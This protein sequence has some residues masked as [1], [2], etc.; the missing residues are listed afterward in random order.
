M[1]SSFWSYRWWG[2]LALGLTGCG[3]RPEFYE[4]NFRSDGAVG[5]ASAVA[6][7]DGAANRVAFLRSPRALE[8]SVDYVPVGRN[9]R[10]VRAS[11]DGTKLFVLSRGVARRRHLDDERP[12][13]TVIDASE[14]TPRVVRDDELA[15]GL[16]ALVVDDAGEWAVIY[17]FGPSSDAYVT[18]PNELILVDLTSNDEPIAVSLDSRGGR[19]LALRFTGAMRMPNGGER[20]FLVVLR[21]HDIA[22][23]DLT[24]LDRQVTVGSPATEGDGDA[25]PIEV[26]EFSGSREDNAKFAIRFE[27]E[28]TIGIVELAEPETG[29]KDRA[30]SI[31]YNLID[32]GGVASS[33]EYVRTDGGVRLAAVV[34]STATAQLIDTVSSDVT[35]VKLG[36][37]FSG[38]KLVTDDID[39]RPESGDVAIL[40]SDRDTA[41]GFWSLGKTAERAY[42]SLET[43]DIGVTV[44]QV[45]DVPGEDYSAYKLLKSQR[46]AQFFVL[47]LNRRRSF[48][49]LALTSAE[50]SVSLD[51]QRVWAYDEGGTELARVTFDDL[52]PVSL[53]T[54]RSI[55]GVFDI[56]RDDGGRAAIALHLVQGEGFGATVFDAFEPDSAHS[57]FFSGFQ[58]TEV[59]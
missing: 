47:D 51:G 15:Q 41:V 44:G 24:D 13:F 25:R 22:L 35:E 8:L 29:E 30:F 58:L 52:H 56:Q 5:L 3:D 12:R 23:V 39:H 20:R 54:E 49:L 28:S 6:V 43:Q 50:L 2:V 9:V 14:G 32:V 27:G 40:Y 37:S 45:L 26:V 1:K 34:P 31:A 55:A 10:T 11:R 38:I 19:P 48:P 59:K 33:I 7:V 16:S 4:L 36:Y 18:N 57:R 53:N 17:D 21:E 46:G 42:R